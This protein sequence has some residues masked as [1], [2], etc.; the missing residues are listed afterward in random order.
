[1]RQTYLMRPTTLTTTPSRHHSLCVTNVNREV[2]IDASHLVMYFAD[3]TDY[4]LLIVVFAV[5]LLLS[6]V[7]NIAL[8]LYIVYLKRRP[9]KGLE[10]PGV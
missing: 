6:V 10:R 2:D 8:I 3:Y 5:P 7:L 1:M 4:L 9:T